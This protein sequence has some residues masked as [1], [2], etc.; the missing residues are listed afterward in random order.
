MIHMIIICHIWFSAISFSTHIM[1]SQLTDASGTTLVEHEDVHVEIEQVTTD[2]HDEDDDNSGIP[3]Y[4]VVS[5][6]NSRNLSKVQGKRTVI[7]PFQRRILEEF[8]RTG[9]NSA[10]HHLHHLHDAAADQTGLELHVI[11]VYLICSLYLYV[12][13]FIGLLVELGS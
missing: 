13:V 10:A 11:K 7:L 1:S 4:G 2:D 5:N 3:P 8:F 9:M 12:V 6:G